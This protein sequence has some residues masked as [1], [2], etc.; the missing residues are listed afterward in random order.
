MKVRVLQIDV[1]EPE[2][3]SEGSAKV[4]VEIDGSTDWFEFTIHPMK[5]FEGVPGCGAGVAVV[6]AEDVLFDRLH[7]DQ[8]TVHRIMNLVGQARRLG[9]VHLPQLVAA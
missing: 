9:S 2:G 1:A 3:D 5:G 6:S 4:L 8:L 7:P